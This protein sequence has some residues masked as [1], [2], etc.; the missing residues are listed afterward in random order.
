MNTISV[1]LLHTATGR[2][3]QADFQPDEQELADFQ[4]LE[5]SGLGASEKY[6][7]LREHIV[8]VEPPP[9]RSQRE[10]VAF[11]TNLLL[12]VAE[13]AAKAPAELFQVFE[14]VQVLKTLAELGAAEGCVAYLG[15]LADGGFF[16]SELKSGLINKI[17]N[18]MTF[19]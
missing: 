5:L 8:P 2:I 19:Q 9:A 17:T 14:A 7:F 1:E 4:A 3:Y 18:F 10:K 12:E 16:T 13:E 11:L 15:Q 6:V